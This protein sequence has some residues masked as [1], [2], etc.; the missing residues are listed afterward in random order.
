MIVNVFAPAVEEPLSLSEVKAHLRLDTSD[1]DALL[2]PMISSAR[3]SVE[4]HT[5][6]VLMRQTRDI[7]LPEFSDLM[8]LGAPLASVVSIS[9]VDPNGASQTVPSTDY[10]VI[11]PTASPETPGFVTLAYGKDWP[12]TRDQINAVTI[13]AELGYASRDAVPASL[14]SAMLLLI[15]DLYENREAQ[16]DALLQENRT[17]QR[18]LSPWVVSWF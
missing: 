13:R 15:G 8:R 5:G 17:V 14:R 1:E 11:A 3:Q 7:I 6:R 4:A 12:S 16:S 18:L 9:Y 2:M 10:L